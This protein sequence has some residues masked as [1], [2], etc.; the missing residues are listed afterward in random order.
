MEISVNQ[1]I[2]NYY[3]TSTSDLIG[4]VPEASIP[5][6]NDE[7]SSTPWEEFNDAVDNWARHALAVN[8]FGG[9]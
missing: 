9:F 8:G 3:A 2:D 7:E 4:T 5:S 1:Y 6:S